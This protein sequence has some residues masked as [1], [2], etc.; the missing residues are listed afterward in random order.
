MDGEELLFRKRLEELAN[1]SYANQQYLFTGFLSAAELDIY[2]QMEHELSYAPAVLFGGTNDCER[3][4]LRFGSEALCG[5]EELFPIA[6]VAIVPLLEKFGEVLSHRDYLGALMNLGIER[7]TLGDIIIEGKH[8]FLFCT[9]QMAPY[10]LENLDK[11]K[12]TNVQCSLA[13]EIPKSTVVQVE[14][15]I[16]QV[17][18]MRADS[19]IAKVYHLS[20]S[21]S[22]NLF[23]AKKVFVNGRQTE[24]N[25]GSLKPEDKVT[26]RGYGRFCCVNIVGESKKGKLNVEVD[27]Y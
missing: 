6:C 26:V 13:K 3:L 8:A 7:S 15:K 25:S 9:E 10:I 12:H 4:M 24:N 2:Y 21:E 22:L 14:R 5:Y 1:R 27:V 16:V 17:G 18:A 19:I 11:I 23:R 20:R